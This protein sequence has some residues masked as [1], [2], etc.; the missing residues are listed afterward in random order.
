MASTSPYDHPDIGTLEASTA[1]EGVLQFLG[2]Q[3]ATL[4][5]RFAPAVVKK[6][7]PGAKI[8]ATKLGYV[9][10]KNSLTGSS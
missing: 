9:P 7:S 6:Y 5:H 1:Q 8:D 10:G 2:V 4:E 3:Y